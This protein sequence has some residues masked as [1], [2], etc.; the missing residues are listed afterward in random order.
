MLSFVLL[1]GLAVSAAEAGKGEDERIWFLRVAVTRL[2]VLG[3]A[4]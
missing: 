2:A 1:V 3:D 4:G